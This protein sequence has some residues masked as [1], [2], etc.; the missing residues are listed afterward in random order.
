MPCCH[1]KQQ[2]LNYVTA[3]TASGGKAATAVERATAV[4]GAAVGA[5]TADLVM[6]HV[7]PSKN[8]VPV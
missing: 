2:L 4:E 1:R 3:I 7:G 5:A 6:L 8:S